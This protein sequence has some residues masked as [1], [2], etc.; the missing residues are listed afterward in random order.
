MKNQLNFI[1]LEGRNMVH[2]ALLSDQRIASVFLATSTLG[3]PR[4][5]EIE[6]LAKKSGVQVLK[7]SPEEIAKMSDS[8]NPQGVIALMSIPE[9]PTLKQILEEKRNA[10]ILLL[11]HIDYEQNLGAILRTAWAAGVDAVIA[12]PNGVHEVTPVVAKVSMGGAAYVPLLGMSM[13]QAIKLLHEYAVP[14][15][16]VEVDKGK[17]FTETKL[18]GPVAFVMGGEA[19]GLSEPL[20]KECDLFVNIPMEKSVASLNVSVATAL[21]LFEKLRQEKG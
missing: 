17:S 13:F 19:V 5:I 8:R 3:D 6:N 18:T 21:V 9:T 2:D 7:V 15:V 11:N 20:Q 1:T 4:I 14:V 10:F 12:S 16:G